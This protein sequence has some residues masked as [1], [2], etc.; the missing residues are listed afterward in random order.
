MLPFTQSFVVLINESNTPRNIFIIEWNH[1]KISI[2]AFITTSAQ[3]L[4]RLHALIYQTDQLVASDDSKAIFRFKMIFFCIIPHQIFVIRFLC[5][6]IGN[7][8]LYSSE[9]F[10]GIFA[11]GLSL[12]HKRYKGEIFS[13][14]YMESFRHYR[15]SRLQRS[16]KRVTF[17]QHIYHGLRQTILTFQVLCFYSFPENQTTAL[18]QYIRNISGCT[19]K[20]SFTGLTLEVFCNFI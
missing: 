2:N 19:T 17:P 10:T 9:K 7:S 12:V 16:P 18:D 20:C 14:K 13:P 11:R 1:Y 5:Q 15:I 3:D 6:G 4:I 8:Q